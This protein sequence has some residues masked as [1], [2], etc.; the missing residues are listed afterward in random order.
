MFGLD[1]IKLS[2][3]QGAKL[4]IAK[5]AK[6]LK[7][8]ARGLKNILDKLLLPYQFDAQEMYNKG[9]IELKINENVITK[10]E[11]PELIF[12]NNRKENEKLQQKQRKQ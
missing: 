12:K 4:E 2:M 1:N 7:T 5:R 11:D 6:E 9:V 3:T 10:G 8:N